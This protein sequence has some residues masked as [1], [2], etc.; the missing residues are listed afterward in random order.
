SAAILWGTFP[1]MRA[2]EY[3]N[4]AA[5]AILWGL[6]FGVAAWLWP[7]GAPVWG[8]LVFPAASALVSL[9][10]SRL[11]G[12]QAIPLL[13]CQERALAIAHVA[14]LGNEITVVALLALTATLPVVFMAHWP[15][16]AR[17]FVWVGAGLVFV[18]ALFLFG[19]LSYRASL[20]RQGGW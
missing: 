17:T 18:L 7:D 12:R 6:V 2:L 4:I 1:F 11:F 10:P 8:L 14:R 20:A 16:S 15:P 5:S 13:R 19:E 3:S 9:L